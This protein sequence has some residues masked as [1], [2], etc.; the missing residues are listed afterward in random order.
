MPDAPTATLTLKFGTDPNLLV[1]VDPRCPAETSVQVVSDTQARAGPGARLQRVDRER[2]GFRYVDKP[3]GPK[4]LRKLTYK[5]GRLTVKLKGDP[6]AGAPLGGPVAFVETR[7][8]IGAHDYCGRWEAPPGIIQRNEVDRVAAKG[9]TLPCQVVCGDGVTQA[10]E[11]CDDGNARD[12]DCCTTACTL[13]PDG[14]ACTDLT[15]CTTGDACQAGACQGTLRAPWINEFDYDDVAALNDDRD[16]FVEIAGPAGTD[17]GGYKLVAVEGAGRLVRDAA[18]VD[19][20]QRERLR[21]H[22]GRDRAGQRYGD[23]HRLPGGVLLLHL[24]LRA[25]VRRGAA[26]AVHRLQPSERPSDQRRPVLLP[27]RRPAAG[28]R[29][30]LRRFGQLRGPGPE[31]RLLR[32]LFPPLPAG[33]RRA[34]RGL[35][36]RRVDREDVEHAGPGD[37][38]AESRDPSELGNVFC[39]GQLGLAC[40]TNTRTPGTKNPTAGARL[41][42]AEWRLRRWGL[43][44]DATCLSRRRR[45][46]LA[47][48]LSDLLACVRRG[49]GSKGASMLGRR[50]SESGWG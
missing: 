8:T 16:E 42:L 41:R 4:S 22:S 15:G 12:D 10:P 34:R 30:R 20:G 18:G 43:S 19:A 11:A 44:G 35:A 27:G 6:Y 28:R 39:T 23:R 33:Y 3:G 31:P 7:I 36:A 50:A 45:R 17:L 13:A 46:Q 5:S 24:G 1:I 49:R 40:P 38:G 2:K 25:R 14:S 47:P 21:D 37:D 48:H 29:Q 32:P 26:R 9:P